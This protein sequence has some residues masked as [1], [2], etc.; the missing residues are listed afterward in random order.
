MRVEERV[1]VEIFSRFEMIFSE[2]L[3][4]NVSFRVRVKILLMFSHGCLETAART[5]L[6]PAYIL[7]R[8]SLLSVEHGECNHIRGQNIYHS[9]LR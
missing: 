3:S 9:V 6:L 4:D 5:S 2:I 7:G 8:N 1:G